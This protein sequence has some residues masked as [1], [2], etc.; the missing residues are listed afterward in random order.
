MYRPLPTGPI[1]LDCDV[2]V[3]TWPAQADIDLS[4]E[5][6]AATL[7]EADVTGAL[8]CSA[9]G[10][11]FDDVDGL[12]ETLS[13]AADRPAWSP[14]VTVNLRNALRAEEL[15]ATASNAGVRTLR[16]FGALQGVPIASPAYR[17]TI[18]LAAAAGITILTDGDVREIWPAFAGQGLRVVFLDVHAYHL[19]DFI[20]LAR[21]EPGFVSSTRL[22]NAPDSIERLVGEVGAQ[23]AAFGSRA[24]LHAIAPST[25]RLR[26]ARIS[27]ED[28][29][30][31]GG[32][33]LTDT[34]VTP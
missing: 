30:T 17:H 27:A 14:V 7:A 6:A 13:L 9:R 20:L 3:G 16:L 2:L 8:V 23:H 4:P 33:W 10:A 28:R 11:W 5:K 21:E 1:A 24:P 32:G 25:L 29:A 31:I 15:L 34:T 18:T 22:L 12:A 19:A 26:H